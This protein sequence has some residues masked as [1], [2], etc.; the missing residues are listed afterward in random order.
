MSTASSSGSG[1]GRGKR[2]LGERHVPTVLGHFAPGQ[3]RPCVACAGSVTGHVGLFLACS[4]GFCPKPSRLPRGASGSGRTYVG[5]SDRNAHRREKWLIC[6]YFP[7]CRRSEIGKSNREDRRRRGFSRGWPPS[8]SNK[9]AL[10]DGT[11][12]AF[13]EVRRRPC[14]LRVPANPIGHEHDARFASDAAH[15]LR[16]RVRNSVGRMSVR[17]LPEIRKVC[18]PIHGRLSRGAT[19][20]D[21]RGT[22]ESAACRRPSEGGMSGLWALN[23]QTGA[24]LH[25]PPNH[26][27]GQVLALSVAGRLL[28]VAGR[29]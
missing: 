10:V 22:T 19:N 18:A 7:I 24:V 14:L 8:G 21:R 6:R 20:L 27:P 13:R 2:L 5:K 9:P 29:T 26:A 23:A 12:E 16:D 28:L 1:P 11:S 15:E 17:G 4:Y 25:L 3:P